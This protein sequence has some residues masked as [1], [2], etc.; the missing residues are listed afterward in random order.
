L[1]KPRDNKET[2]M[3]TMET[4]V[5]TTMTGHSVVSRQEWLDARLA[6]LAKEKE[7]TR[8]RDALARE[9]QQLPWERVEK[10]YIFDS[11]EGKKTLADLFGDKSQLLIYHFMFAPDWEQGCQSCSMAT[12]TMDANYLHLT[13]RDVAL[14]MVSRA[15]MEKITLFKKRMGWSVPWV[16][17]YGN[18][19]NRDFG[20][21]F[22]EEEVKNSTDYNFGTSRPYGE[23]TPGLSAFSKGGV[24]NVY[25]TYSTYGRGLEG[26]LGVY[27]LLDVA[28]KGRDEGALPWPMAWVK[29]HDRYETAKPAAACCAH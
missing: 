14:V 21:S 29:H 25:H 3:A 15:P 19:F 23:E 6:L 8:Q 16:S 5:E 26:I 11:L 28:P 2:T 12:D 27:T 22:S 4:T 20:V 7:L 17:S 10:N 13:Q 24:G 9:R 18:D 1:N